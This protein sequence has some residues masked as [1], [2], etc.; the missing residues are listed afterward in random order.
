MFSNPSHLLSSPS[1]ILNTLTLTHTHT[2]KAIIDIDGNNWSARFPYLLCTNSIIIRITPD[3]IEQQYTSATTT[4]T[5]TTTTTAPS[6]NAVFPNVHYI[7]A[8]ITN[9]TSVIEHVINIQN[10]IQIQEIVQ[11]AN[12][13][14]VQ[15]LTK[16]VFINNAITTL[17]MYQQA[18]VHH[19][20]MDDNG[21]VGSGVDNIDDLVECNV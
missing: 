12:D 13:W 7:P 19:G 10:D 18:L 2:I 16:D 4:T 15:Q 6:T 20:V 9:L 8:S 1:T 14:C 11:N 5:I 3:F 21:R 17:D